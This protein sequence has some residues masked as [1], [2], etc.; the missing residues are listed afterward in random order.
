MRTGVATIGLTWCIPTLLAAVVFGLC[1]FTL[2]QARS[3]F[4]WYAEH[5]ISPRRVWLS[6][7]LVWLPLVIL[8]GAGVS[9]FGN[10]PR[11]SRRPAVERA[12]LVSICLWIPLTW[13]ALGQFCAMFIRSTLVAAITALVLGVLSAAWNA[14]M[15][16]GDVPLAWSVVPVPFVLLL[17]TWLYAPDWIEERWNRRVALR[18][19]TV[20]GVPMLL[21]AIAVPVRRAYQIPLVD[22]GF[23]VAEFTRPL[24]AAEEETLDLYYRAWQAQRD[25][26][27]QM[28][29]LKGREQSSYERLDARRA[30][31]PATTAA[32]RPTSRVDAAQAS[33]PR[34]RGAVIAARREA[35]VATR[36]ATTVRGPGVR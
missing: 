9:L 7:H 14:F 6:R 2:D 34:R 8:A 18:L 27:Q 28:I 10:D 15:V 29:P 4:R 21:L 25:S 11:A 24:T 32:R 36:N 19:A 30:A 23:S 13:Y 1:V 5:G 35:R 26:R 3:Q 22:P 20:V 12:L 31:Y 33:S 16:F 17:A